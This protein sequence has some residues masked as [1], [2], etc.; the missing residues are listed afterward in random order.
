MKILVFDTETNGLPKSKNAKIFDTQQ[1]PYILQLSY[2][3]YDVY[4][5]N[6]IK[7]TNNY[8][9]NVEFNEDAYKINKITKEMIEN[10]KNIK[11]VLN[12]FIDAIKVCD[13]LVAHNCNFDKKIIMVECVRNQILYRL[14]YNIKNKNTFC[15]MI[16][17]INLCKL[18]SN[19]ENGN[20]K[21]PKLNELYN[22]L[23]NENIP[24]DNLHNSLVDCIFTLKCYIKL[25]YNIDL[26]K[27]NN[28]FEI[29]LNNLY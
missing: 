9:N 18:P 26:F 20:F 8:I 6:I 21:F 19:F 29:I 27:I 24:S 17:S 23:F 7:T 16:N 14:N 11:D 10:G 13:I 22:Y 5:N 1:F 28:R 12:D 15:T 25:K 2:I 3:I 4:N